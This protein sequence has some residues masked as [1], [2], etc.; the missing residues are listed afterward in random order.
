MAQSATT[1]W[2]ASRH[3][4]IREL[5]IAASFSGGV[6]LAVWM[7]GL[8]YELD[9]LLRAS[10]V[11]RERRLS[12][13]A[14]SR[15]EEPRYAALLSLLGIDVD[16]DIITGTSAGGIN[17]AALAF[18]RVHG[19][20]LAKL[21][22]VW[23]E[24]GS[25]STLMRPVSDKEPSSLLQGDG[26]LLRGI[27][28]GLRAVKQDNRGAGRRTVT[29]PADGS[30]RSNPL[31]LFVTATM[32]SP[33]ITVI[34][35]SLGT[36]VHLEDNQALFRFEQ[37]AGDTPGT[38]NLDIAALARAARSSASYPA[39]F[40]PSFVPVGETDGD[41]V[42]MRSHLGIQSSRWMLDGGLR[43]NQPVGPALRAVWEQPASQ[44]VRRV[45]LHIVPD[46]GQQAGEA[47]V[48]DQTPNITQ[49]LSS[50]LAA[51][52]IQ[53]WRAD[54]EAARQQAR[55]A[56]RRRQGSTAVHRL[57]EADVDSAWTA[58]S[59]E[60][61]AVRAGWVVEDF[62]S[63]LD[64]QLGRFG[65][66]GRGPN[67]SE[68]PTGAPL[69]FTSETHD[70]ALAK[71]RATAA[72][73]FGTSAPEGLEGSGLALFGPDFLNA[74]VADLLAHLRASEATP[75]DVGK[76]ARGLYATLP[77]ERGRGF[78][79]ELLTAFVK[80]EIAQND[81]AIDAF[82]VERMFGLWLG[83]AFPKPS[84]QVPEPSTAHAL[85]TSWDS[86]ASLVGGACSHS[87]DRARGGRGRAAAG[88]PCPQRHQPADVGRW[89]PQRSGRRA[90]PDVRAHAHTANA[91]L[92][93][94]RE[95]ARRRDGPLRRVRPALLAGERLDVGTTRRGG[96]AGA[97]AAHTAAPQGGRRRTRSPAA[98]KSRRPTRCATR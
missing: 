86:A 74:C 46:P 15:P 2:E 9:R 78:E 75:D 62:V 42:D 18:A 60:L 91:A 92:R 93:A 30:S 96:M 34:R 12:A 23:L 45:L 16:V 44:R 4:D 36:A 64:A 49:A 87:I 82:A 72:R 19:S 21:R 24:R 57:I 88:E 68:G 31:R 41:G 53:S 37:P 28:A 83:E 8:T 38:G 54:L 47:A 25:F 22:D 89:P 73:H 63:T 43:N 26:V 35:D 77:A 58:L 14:T 69:R 20:S 70:E 27:E 95:A 79:S 50:T 85:R 65:S 51:P 11:E 48:R 1:V 3:P 56:R 81:K 59:T 80:A 40:E 17:G 97:L 10:D 55:S 6:S 7:G 52:F 94:I 33:D 84:T 39:A 66:A 98:T 32:T 61:L 13:S 76:A 67:A 5:R 71:C 90:R 29:A